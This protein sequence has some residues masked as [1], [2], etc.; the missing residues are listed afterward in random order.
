MTMKHTILLVATISAGILHGA[1]GLTMDEAYG[2]NVDSPE[3]ITKGVKVEQL[4]ATGT[5]GSN[6]NLPAGQQKTNIAA[7]AQK[8]IDYSEA[9][10][11]ILKDNYYKSK[12]KTFVPVKSGTYDAGE[13]P[14]YVTEWQKKKAEALKTSEAKEATK[15]YDAIYFSGVCENENSLEIS[16]PAVLQLYCEDK[17]GNSARIDAEIKIT[18]ADGDVQLKAVPTKITYP[19]NKIYFAQ[20]GTVTHAY[21]GSYNIATFADARKK[22]KII[23]NVTTAAA[24]TIPQHTKEYLEASKQAQQ[25]SSVIVTDAG[26]LTQSNNQKPDAS[27]YIAG[28]AVDMVATG[29]KAIADALYTDLPYIFFVPAKTSFVVETLAIP[30]EKKLADLTKK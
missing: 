24:T 30:I 2:G 25:Q 11:L 10:V 3:N 18:K 21:T 5:S 17:N 4:T 23:K 9:G 15:S 12:E 13:N 29:A 1:Q 6:V 22:E 28:A 26:Y 14:K 8:P 27:D 16:G 19:G 7:Q 20:D